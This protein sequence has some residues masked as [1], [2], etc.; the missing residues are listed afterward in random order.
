MILMAGISLRLKVGAATSS[1]HSSQAKAC[2]Y[3]DLKIRIRKFEIVAATFRLRN[4]SQAKA[5]G[6]TYLTTYSCE[7]TRSDLRSERLH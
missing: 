5:C 2:G 4:Y 6:Y 1:N 7:I 3:I